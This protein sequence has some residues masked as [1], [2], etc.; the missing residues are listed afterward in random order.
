M[1]ASDIAKLNDEFRADPFNNGTVLVSKE[2]ERLNPPSDWII[3]DAIKNVDIFPEGN[4]EHDRG[5]LDIAFVGKV[6]WRILY[7]D[8]R[9]KD[10]S[11]NPADPT[12]THRVLIVARPGEFNL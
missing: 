3:F 2:I 9:F 11:P 4:A 5:I 6:Y 12:V 10:I 7:S 1:S 8:T